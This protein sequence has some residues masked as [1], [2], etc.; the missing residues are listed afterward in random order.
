MK[1]QLMLMIAALV[2]AGSVYAKNPVAVIKT[3]M[4]TIK[5]ELYQTDAPKTVKNFVG[6]AEKNF[7][8]GI[9]FHRISRGFVIQAGDPFTKDKSKMSQWGMGGESIYGGKAFEDELNANAPSYKAGYQK[10]VL[11]MANS[12]P[13]TNKSQFFILLGDQTSWMPHNY[14]IFGK[15]ISGQ[16]VVDKIGQEP[17]AGGQKDGRPTNDIVIQKITIE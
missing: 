17:I 11:A 10:G 15:V 9:L 6:L 8:D 13:N 1:I 12:G 4:G 16:D 5:C 14:T 3:S 7:Y 2:A